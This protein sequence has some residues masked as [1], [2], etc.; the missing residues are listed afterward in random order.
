MNSSPVQLI[1]IPQQCTFS[2]FLR[3]MS[4]TGKAALEWKNEQLHYGSESSRLYHT[5]DPP[6]FPAAWDIFPDGD[7][8]DRPN[9]VRSPPVNSDS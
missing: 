3:F 5:F 2:L 7:N 6:G 4:P 1:K 8:S 9:G